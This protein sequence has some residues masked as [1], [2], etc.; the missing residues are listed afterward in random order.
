MPTNGLSL[1]K[2]EEISISLDQGT[3]DVFLSWQAVTGKT[4]MITGNTNLNSDWETIASGIVATN[5]PAQ[6]ELQT[7]ASTKF[8]KIS[9]E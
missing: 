4:Y 3:N 5:T 7:D 8:F 2:L 6:Y 1:L 9:L